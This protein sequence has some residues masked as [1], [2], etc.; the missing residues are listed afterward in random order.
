MQYIQ[1]HAT[2]LVRADLPCAL[3]G[4]LEQCRDGVTE[5]DDHGAQVR[6]ASLMSSFTA[7]SKRPPS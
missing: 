5:M 7:G 2:D 6:C 1:E 3:W 4:W